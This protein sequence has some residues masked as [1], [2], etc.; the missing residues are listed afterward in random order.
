MVKHLSVNRS[1]LTAQQSLSKN[2]ISHTCVTTA[3]TRLQENGVRKMISVLSVFWYRNHRFYG[4]ES[5]LK[6]DTTIAYGDYMQVD[7]DHFAIWD[8]YRKQMGIASSR[9]EY[10]AVP[11]GRI[12]F[13]IPTHHF[14]V[15][16]SK[17]IVDN[18][19][20]RSELLE[21]FNLPS[22]TEFKHDMH[23]R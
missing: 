20:V 12:L 8:K 9:I 19:A 15:I 6:S 17:A 16:G 11:R 10:D 22:N 13:H 14:V 7:A 1:I 18:Y 5:A 2:S 3:S 21:W 23:Y 4:E